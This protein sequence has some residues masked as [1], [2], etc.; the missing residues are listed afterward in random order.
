[1]V[2]AIR[3]FTTL[4][5]P[6]WATVASG[7]LFIV[8]LQAVLFAALLTVLVLSSRQQAPFVPSRDFDWYIARTWTAFSS[9][10]RK[11]PS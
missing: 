2:V 11:Q 3:L 7:I 1:V 5:I 10:E 6:G 8:L 4:A 9:D